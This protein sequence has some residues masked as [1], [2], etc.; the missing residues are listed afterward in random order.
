MLKLFG[1]RRRNRLLKNSKMVHIKRNFI[2]ECI[3][4]IIKREG[5]LVNH[6]LDRGGITKYG[7]TRKSYANYFNIPIDQV[8][9]KNIEDLTVDT[10]KDIY[11]NDY[12]IKFSLD[13]L[14]WNCIF[15]QVL[16]MAV[17]HGPINA[18]KIMQKPLGVKPDGIIGPITVQSLEQLE[19]YGSGSP[20]I[21]T[22]SR[23]ICLDRV[24]FVIRIAQ[25]DLSQ[26]AFL[27]GWILRALE[28]YRWDA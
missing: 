13:K 22:L 8:L 20:Q 23:A 9:A 12:V 11:N 14:I 6:P 16:D 18:I 27:E 4:N 24:Q 10:A 26:V 3:H 28:F 1:T 2:E 15:D 25:R 7:I 17:L 21:Q 5:G 19:M